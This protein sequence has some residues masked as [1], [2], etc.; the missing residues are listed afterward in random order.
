MRDRSQ[1]G[2]TS[3]ICGGT[4][5]TPERAW[6]FE[7]WSW[8]YTVICHVA[9]RQVEGVNIV[10]MVPAGCA[11]KAVA[12]I[13]EELSQKYPQVKF[14]KIDIDNQ[15][16]QAVVNDHGITGV[17]S[18]C[19]C[20]AVLQTTRAHMHPRS[21][22][23]ASALVTEQSGSQDAFAICRQAVSLSGLLPSPGLVQCVQHSG[24]DWRQLLACVVAVPAQPTCSSASSHELP[25]PVLS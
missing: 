11:G 2:P 3:S 5:V 18:W 4:E 15:D 1:T 16:M 14:L 25:S 17:V 9:L 10:C 22:A 7:P 8:Q 24:N 23:A 6:G 12:P 21:T 20:C 19:Y 13:Y